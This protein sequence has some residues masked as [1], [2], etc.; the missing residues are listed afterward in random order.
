MF[1]IG[2]SLVVALVIGKMRTN[3]LSNLL[4]NAQV[5]VLNT[6]LSVAFFLSDNLKVLD[7]LDHTCT[8][9]NSSFY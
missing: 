9:K 4:I 7:L 8:N 1:S 5:Q 2:R 3:Q 6:Y